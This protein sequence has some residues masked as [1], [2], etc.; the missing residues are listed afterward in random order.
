MG[1]EPSLPSQAPDQIDQFNV[2]LITTR[3]HV[4]KLAE[5]QAGAPFGP[6]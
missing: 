4:Q 2:D 5:T 6:A 3:A 1:D